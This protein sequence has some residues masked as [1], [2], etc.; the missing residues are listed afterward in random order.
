MDESKLSDGS[1]KLETN[2]SEERQGDE[3][4]TEPEDSDK[5]FHQET[6]DCKTDKSKDEEFENYSNT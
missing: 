1:S 3:H 2:S 6:S 5:M 4:Y